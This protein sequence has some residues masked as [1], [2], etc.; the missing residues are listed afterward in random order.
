MTEIPN[1]AEIPD[2]GSPQKEVF[3]YAGLALFTAQVWE[4]GMTTF[5]LIMRREEGTLTT[6]EDWDTNEEKLLSLTAGILRNTIEK[7]G[8][9]PTKTLKFWKKTLQSRN[10]LAHG[11]FERHA[12][13]FMLPQGRQ[14]MLNELGAMIAEFETADQKTDEA[15][16]R[17]KKRWGVTDE[18][19][20]DMENELM[21]SAK[22]NLQP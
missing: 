16:E 8:L 11:F 12:E 17:V 15:S 7:E 19:I 21:K 14:L 10:R 20:R 1:I 4:R 13:N 2:D 6:V 18:M 22:E 3:A 9:A 5:A